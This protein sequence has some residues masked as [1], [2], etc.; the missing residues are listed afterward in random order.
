MLTRSHATGGAQLASVTWPL[1]RALSWK[2]PVS[3]IGSALLVGALAACG[4]GS[5]TAPTSSDPATSQPATGAPA[6]TSPAP[7]ASSLSPFQQAQ[8]WFASV[9]PIYTSIQQDTEAIKLAAG[10][11]DVAAIRNAC[12]ALQVDD[13]KARAAPAPPD[14]LM[15]A[16]VGSATDAYA[17]AARACLAGDYKTTATQINQGAYYLQRANDIMNNMD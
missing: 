8:A 13:E 5:G 14:E 3:W 15:V 16:A 7:G 12:E 4:S 11:Q 17:K 1:V 9:Q 10:K 2:N 6:G